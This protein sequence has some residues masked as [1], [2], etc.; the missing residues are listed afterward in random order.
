MTTGYQPLNTLKSVAE[1]LWIIDGSPL[2][3]SGFP[4]P[5]RS[6]AV[7]L[8]SGELWVHSPVAYEDALHRELDQIGP[9]GHFFIPHRFNRNVVDDWRTSFPNALFW[10]EARTSEKFANEG[11]DAGFENILNP[12]A[13]RR[14]WD[15]QMHQ[16]AIRNGRGHIGMAFF[17]VESRSLILSDLIMAIE[18][19]KIP[20]K[21][22]P[23]AWICGIDDSD[24]RMPPSLR[25]SIRD[26]NAFSEDIETL[27]SWRPRRVIISHG[28]WYG[29]N[30][31]GELERAFR[32]YLHSHRW[33]K[34]YERMRGQRK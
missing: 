18:T 7:R 9:V 26:K 27:I 28:R 14:Q 23:W 24:G 12:D 30:G 22:R 33:E 10:S 6:V 31:R 2:G 17:H 21:Y 19:A 3:S 15:G 11:A 13:N 20:V 4:L 5:T 32:R 34:A 29:E 25:W 8:N 1:G 16:L